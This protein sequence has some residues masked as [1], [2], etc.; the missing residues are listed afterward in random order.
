MPRGTERIEDHKCA[1]SFEENYSMQL[2]VYAYNAYTT[3]RKIN[4]FSGSHMA[5]RSQLQNVGDHHDTHKK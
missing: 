5:P 2:Q 1:C 4:F 3:G